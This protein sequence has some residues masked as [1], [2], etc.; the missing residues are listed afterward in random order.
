MAGCL[1]EPGPPPKCSCESSPSDLRGPELVCRV[2][3]SLS[4]ALPDT[5]SDALSDTLSDGLSDAPR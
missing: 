2:G 5:L 1:P 3:L 4:D